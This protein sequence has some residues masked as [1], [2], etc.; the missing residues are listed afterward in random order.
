MNLIRVIEE[1]MM[2]VLEVIF[3]LLLQKNFYM[4][5][6]IRRF[7]EN[8]ANYFLNIIYCEYQLLW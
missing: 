2:N 6:N 5:K 4:A 8:L 1:L 3:I 7:C